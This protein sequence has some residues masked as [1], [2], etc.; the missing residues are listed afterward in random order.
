[1]SADAARLPAQRSISAWSRIYGFGSVYAKTLRDSRLALLIVGGIVAAV[2]LSSGAAFGEAYATPQSRTDLAAL[3]HSLPPALAG[4]YGSPFPAKIETLGG[5]IAWKS[6]GSIGLTVA[7]WSIIAMSGTLAAEARRGSLELVAVTPVGA[8]R[9]ALEKLAAHLTGMG[10]VAIV[11]A[12]AAWAAA[13]AF[14]TLPGDQITPIEALGFGA[15]VGAVGLASGSVAFAIAPFLGRVAAAG[16][17]GALMLAGYFL[18]GY[19]ATAPAFS[20]FANLTWFGWT[21]RH[22]PLVGQFD[23]VSLIPVALVAA[24]L[25]VIGVEA[26]ARRDLGATGGIALPGLPAVALGLRDATARSFGERIPLALAW[27]SGIGLFGLV[28][29]AAA[30]SFGDALRNVSPET[31]NVMRAVFPSIDLNSAG[32]FLQLTFVELGF[33]LVGFAAATLV[34]GW[35]SDEREGR[36]E[37]LLTTPLSRV[38]WALQSGIG[39][40]AAVGCMTALLAAGIGVGAALGGGDVVTPILG[41]V[42]LGLYAAALAG[43]GLAVGGLL[44]ASIAAEA[45]AAVVILTFLVDLVVPALK[46]PDA[47]RQLAITAHLGQPMIGTWDP[48]GI[49]ICLGLAAA[50]LAA[51]AWGLARRDV[52]R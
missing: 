43:I 15:W 33:I 12:L 28:L 4:I 6:G 23:W 9:I 24:A 42:V 46:L 44:R 35:A 16:L 51:G 13:A 22:Q 36:L 34:S 31:L 29:G 26:F 19:Q 10:I 2:L 45:V 18:N 1:M 14:G 38:R 27:G 39:L 25:F 30:R 20:G 8:R 3:V 50:G 7:L 49:A 17:A 40:L 48:V 11:V 52:Q 47:L 32:A 37:M 41:S 21:V 5:T